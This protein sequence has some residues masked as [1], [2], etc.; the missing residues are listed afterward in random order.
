M[1]DRF[2]LGQYYDAASPVHSLDPRLKMVVTLLYMAALFVTQ[3]WQVYIALAAIFIAVIL[4]S[5]VP[6]PYFWRGMR[7]IVIFMFFTL[8]ANI[9]FT[10]GDAVL[11]LGFITITKEGLIRGGLMGIR[12]FLLVAFATLLTLTTKPVSLTEGMESLLLPLKIIKFPAHEISMVMSI[13][14][15]FI[16][17]ILEEL[18]RIMN[19]QRVRGVDFSSGGLLKRA[20]ALVPLLVPLFIS[21]FRRADELAQAMEAKCYTGKN[22]RTHW[23]PLR[24]RMADTLVLL[25]FAAVLATTIII[26]IL[27]G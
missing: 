24:W 3:N 15:R 20:K 27:R 23:K 14:L 17:T 6:L 13:A 4:V 10:P 21:S 22:H 11:Q 25:F 2:L 5:R 19:A 12:L 9:F 8:A 18:E 1:K 26:N 16:P 7:L